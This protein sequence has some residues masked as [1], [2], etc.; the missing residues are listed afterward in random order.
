MILLSLDAFR[1]LELLAGS[2]SLVV[3]MW[4]TVKLWRDFDK[5]QRLFNCSF[6]FLLFTAI[7]DTLTFLRNDEAFSFRGI[8]YL[9]G[10]LCAFVYILEPK[11]SYMS[12]VHEDDPVSSEPEEDVE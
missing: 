11:R 12:R 5:G 10:V 6:I 9:L 4:R 7:W 8:P 3:I 1:L 2:I